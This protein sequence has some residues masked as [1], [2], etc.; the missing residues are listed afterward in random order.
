M[1]LPSQKERRQ[2]RSTNLRDWYKI[3][4]SK[5]EMLEEELLQGKLLNCRSEL[6]N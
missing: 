4:L 5:D 1:Q 6:T 3:A 2:T